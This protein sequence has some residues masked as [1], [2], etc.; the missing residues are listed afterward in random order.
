MAKRLFVL[1]VVA[2][3][4]V[5]SRSFAACCADSAE[6]ITDSIGCEYRDKF[7]ECSIVA[8]A[9]VQGYEPLCNI[10]REFISEQLG[11]TYKDGYA[12]MDSLISYYVKFHSAEL[13]DMT[14]ELERTDFAGFPYSYYA[15]IRKIYETDR[16][17]TYQT[18]ITQYFGGAHPSTFA[19]ARTFRK[20]D[21]RRFGSEIFNEKFNLRSEKLI[22]DGLKKYFEV[23]TDDELRSCLLNIAPYYTIPMPQNPP[24][25]TK[26]GIVLSYGQYEIAPYAAGMPGLVIPYDEVKSLLKVSAAELIK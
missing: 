15:S 9:P 26:D 20:S 12:D 4:L 7:V 11:G 8:D 5:A 2:A 14:K 25:F 23:T 24:Y 19:S 10:I 22:K 18:V 13:H 16:L 17:V 6:I 1:P 21:G 3:F